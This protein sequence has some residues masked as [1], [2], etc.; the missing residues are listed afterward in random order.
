MLFLCYVCMCK[1]AELV[2]YVSI[3]STHVFVFMYM[4]L[5]AVALCTY[6]YYTP[7]PP[8]RA[9]L[10][11]GGDLN[12]AKVKCITYWA[13]QSVKSQS[14]PHQKDG[15]LWEDLPVNA[16]TFVHVYG[17]LWNSSHTGQVLVSNQSKMPLYIPGGG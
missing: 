13:N 10:G 2:S 8:S 5:H 3:V 4:W 17:R 7:L 1:W 14:S 6:Q 12:Y 15:D 11:R 16:H 9:M